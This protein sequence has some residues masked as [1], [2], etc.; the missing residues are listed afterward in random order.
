MDKSN[1]NSSYGQFEVEGSYYEFHFSKDNIL[2]TRDLTTQPGDIILATYPRTGTTWVQNIM[3]GLMKGVNSLDKLGEKELYFMFPYVEFRDVMQ[4]VVPRMTQTPR[5]FKTHLP[6][7]LAPQECLKHTDRKILVT[8]RNPKD[9]AVSQYKFY[10]QVMSPLYDNITFDQFIDKFM[11]GQVTSGDYWQWSKNWIEKAAKSENILLFHYEDLLDDFEGT[12]QK[13]DSFLDTKRT[14]D[15]IAE[16]K[17]ATDASTM[18][19]KYK[20]NIKGF[21]GTAQKHN[22]KSEISEE[23]AAKF[24]KKSNEYFGS[25]S[26]YQKFL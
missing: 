23:V 10:K 26:F 6:V 15:E 25:Y 5:L 17:K 12:V 3:V 18:R 24:D 14:R 1:M 7:Q 11:N 19:E 13:I 9:T 20:S 2:A 21:V 22:W 8:I 16:L 4:T